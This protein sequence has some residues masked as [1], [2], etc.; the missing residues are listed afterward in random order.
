MIHTTS[1]RTVNQALDLPSDTATV[2]DV[3]L[4]TRCGCQHGGRNRKS[5]GYRGVRDTS[6]RHVTILRWRVVG[7]VPLAAMGLLFHRSAEWSAAI[8]SRSRQSTKG[9]EVDMGHL[10][11]ALTNTGQTPRLPCIPGIPRGE[12]GFAGGSTGRWVPGKVP[13]KSTP[14]LAD[15]SLYRSFRILYRVD[16]GLSSLCQSINDSDHLV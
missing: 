2:I 13:D 9:P 1:S 12:T 11:A 8:L 14:D 6:R 4:V 15:Q 16:M 10:S 5:Y 7:C 3:R